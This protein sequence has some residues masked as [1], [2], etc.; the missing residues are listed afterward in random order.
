MPPPL[1][2]TPEDQQLIAKVAA[3]IV[4]RRLAAPA[5][6]ALE[7]GR[8]LNFIASQFLVFLHPFATALLKPAEYERFTRILEHREGVDVLI[9]AISRT[10]EAMRRNSGPS[11]AKT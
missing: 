4:K 6:M 10:D 11:E 1:V 7:M 3:M 5:I 2:L 9:E 8:P